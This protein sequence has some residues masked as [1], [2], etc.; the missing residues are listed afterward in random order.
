M[1]QEMK[2]LLQMVWRVS[3][4]RLAGRII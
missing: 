1:A 4:Q 2:L 3:Y